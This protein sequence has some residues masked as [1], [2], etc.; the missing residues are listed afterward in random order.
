MATGYEDRCSASLLPT[1]RLC[2]LTCFV[3]VGGTKLRD[4]HPSAQENRFSPK[5]FGKRSNH[6]GLGLL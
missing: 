1:H 6:G 3:E 2:H 4:Q 5:N